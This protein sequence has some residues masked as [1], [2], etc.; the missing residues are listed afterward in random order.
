MQKQDFKFKYNAE[1]N[2]HEATFYGK[3]VSLGEVNQVNKV[4]GKKYAV[5]SV[6]FTNA[7]GK[8]TTVGAIAFEKNVEKGIK[9]GT[10]YLCNVIITEDRPDE[11]LISISS[12][13]SAVRATLKDFAFI[14][15][16]VNAGAEQTV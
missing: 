7:E 4:T 1:Y 11:P 12:L 14:P 15:T 8:L 2:Q 5:G 10:T 13:T 16:E 3:V 6:E 9:I